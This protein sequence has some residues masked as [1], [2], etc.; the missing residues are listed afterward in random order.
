[1]DYR[2]ITGANNE[3][4]VEIRVREP[5]N[6]DI[7]HWV[8]ATKQNLTEIT[9]DEI[10]RIGNLDKEIKSIYRRLELIRDCTYSIGA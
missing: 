6:D 10:R 8:T 7:Y 3:V 9:T 2:I 1:M 5:E 4:I